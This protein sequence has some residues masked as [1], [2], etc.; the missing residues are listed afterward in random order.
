MHMRVRV[1]YLCACM[2]LGVRVCVGVYGYVRP[3]VRVSACACMC[4][5]ACVR[6]C[7]CAC[8]G[9]SDG[10]VGGKKAQKRQRHCIERKAGIR[11][12]SSILIHTLFRTRNGRK[13]EGRETI[14][15]RAE[16]R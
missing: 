7:V 10:K 6:V 12:V 3:C 11:T 15:H 5:C 2:I 13:R 16:A 14:P 1:L 8:V 4:V 9:A